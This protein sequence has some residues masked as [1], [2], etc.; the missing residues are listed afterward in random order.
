L[1]NYIRGH[2]KSL[3]FLLTI[4]LMLS[5]ARGG[6]GRPLTHG[7]HQLSEIYVK[8]LISLAERLVMKF[9]SLSNFQ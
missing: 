8:L 3:I 2:Y 9:V 5:D 7:M 6:F 4:L 1:P